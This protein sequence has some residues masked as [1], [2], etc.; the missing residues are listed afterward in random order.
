VSLDD[1]LALLRARRS[2]RSFKP[3]APPREL[4]ERLIEAAVLAPSASNAQPWRFVVVAERAT[5][6]R[7][8]QGV[9]AAVERIARAVEPAAEA[10]YRAY[11]EYFTRFAA[12]PLV[13]AI[14]HRRLSILSN[15]VG[16][17][18]AADDLRRIDRM[19]ASSGAIGAS[20]ALGHL[21]LAAQAA[22]L[23]ASGMTGPLVADDVLR[24]ELSVPDGWEVLALVPIG[25]PAEGP[26]PT[27]RKPQERVTRWIM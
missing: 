13:V 1:L 6:E 10:S 5:I 20:L 23:G 17:S 16:P 9:R 2:V 19:E 7:L 11:G 27:Q 8:E 25:Y 18:L 15:L 24:R 21:L 12:A 3:D 14:L 26:A 22:G 4:V